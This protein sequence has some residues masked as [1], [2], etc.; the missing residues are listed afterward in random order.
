MIYTQESKSRRM[1][2]LVAVPFSSGLYEIRKEKKHEIVKCMP[3]L[4]TVYHKEKIKSIFLKKGLQFQSY[5]CI[6]IS[7]REKGSPQG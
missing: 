4:F 5:G 1:A 6:L 7:E 2:L 3:L